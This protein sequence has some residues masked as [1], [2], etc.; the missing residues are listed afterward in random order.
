MIN[1]R[2]LLS[3]LILNTWR[4]KI[5]SSY[6]TQDYFED[7]VSVQNTRKDYFDK[8]V[9]LG[10]GGQ[11]TWYYRTVLL[12][13]GRLI[14]ST[15][16]PSLSLLLT[17]QDLRHTNVF[18]WLGI[19]FGLPSGAAIRFL[20]GHSFLKQTGIPLI[21]WHS[22]CSTCVV[23]SLIF[24]PFITQIWWLSILTFV[25]VQEQ[26]LFPRTFFW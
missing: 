16:I 21:F 19:L 10:L 9:K 15:F 2:T 5:R 20:S 13:S 17:Q 11:Y 1:W 23:L 18:S 7:L 6:F 8:D 26:Y 22:F 24:F 3:F 25:F 4:E 14:C 12:H